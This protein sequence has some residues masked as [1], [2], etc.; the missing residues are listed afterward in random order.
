MNL[1]PCPFCGND[2]NNQDPLDTVYPADREDTLYQV[3]CQ[4]CSA[5]ILGESR[6]DAISCWNMRTDN[7]GQQ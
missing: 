4:V 7:Q 5:T 2:L 6:Q 3:V 1:K